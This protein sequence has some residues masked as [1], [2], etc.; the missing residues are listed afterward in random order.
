MKNRILIGA[1]FGLIAAF[2]FRGHAG[3]LIAKE[4]QWHA[5]P[6][7]QAP[8]AETLKWVEFDFNDSEWSKG[9]APF[10]YGDGAGGTEI[11]GMR[12][13]YSTY[14]LRRHFSVDCLLRAD[15]ILN[16]L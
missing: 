6:G 4:S 16:D 12:N 14:F 2:S 7:N 9:S 5:W 1:F 3:T 11:N 13:T 10:R 8:S 15:E